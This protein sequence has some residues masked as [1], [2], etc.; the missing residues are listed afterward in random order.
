MG[1]EVVGEGASRRSRGRLE[2][3]ERVREV[4]RARLLAAALDVVGEHGWE[5]MT[6]ARVTRHAGVSSKTFYEVFAER[7]DCFLGVFDGAVEQLAAVAAGVYEREGEWAAKLRAALRALLEFLEYEPF[8]R[9]VVFI[10]AQEVGPKVAGS[11]TRVL[12]RLVA[13]VDRGRRETAPGHRSPHS[14]AQGVL[15]GVLEVIERWLLQPRLLRHTYPLEP[16]PVPMTD[17]LGELM[18]IVVMPYLGPDAAQRE[19]AR[20]APL[21]RRPRRS[22]SSPAPPVASSRPVVDPLAGLG[23]RLTYRTLRV[24]EA[25]AELGGRGSMGGRAPN[26]RQVADAA[27]ISNHSQVSRLLARLQTL[28]LVENGNEH[29]E[30]KAPNTW[31]LTPRGEEIERAL[32]TGGP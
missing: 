3:R 8:L 6:V 32:R 17:L 2:G 18:S 7:E 20:P 15:D 16:Q 19:L 9:R 1:A 24:L 10:D 31:R 26:N 22:A 5:G 11:R 4:Q 13:I 14:A 12:E 29:S 30:K 23:M 27:E 21:A 28:G 25:L